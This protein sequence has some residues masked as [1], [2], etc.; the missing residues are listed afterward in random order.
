[1]AYDCDGCVE[2][3]VGSGVPAQDSF[4]SPTLLALGCLG[5]NVGLEC[6]LNSQQKGDTTVQR[7]PRAV[8]TVTLLLQSSLGIHSLGIAEVLGKISV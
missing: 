4:S 5:P 8:R 3:S 6:T 7:G 2:R 1:M